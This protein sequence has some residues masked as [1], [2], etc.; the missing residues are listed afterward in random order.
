MVEIFAWLFFFIKVKQ[1]K[2]TQMEQ[3]EANGSQWK[4]SKAINKNPN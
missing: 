2:W 4:Q 1:S 3:I